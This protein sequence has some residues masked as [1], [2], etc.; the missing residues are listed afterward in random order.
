MTRGD[1]D[2]IE[3]FVAAKDLLVDMVRVA[4]FDLEARL[5]KPL[6]I[7]QTLTVTDV[8]RTFKQHR[9]TMALIVNEYG[10]FQGL[11]TLHDVLE[12]YEVALGFVFTPASH[13]TW[14]VSHGSQRRAHSRA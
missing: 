7:P 2:N 4:P 10:E 8:M 6:Y 14:W 12:H 13:H 11:V 1:L 5:R 9:Q 3:G